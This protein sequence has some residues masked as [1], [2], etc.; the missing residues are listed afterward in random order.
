MTLFCYYELLLFSNRFLTCIKLHVQLSVYVTC[1][2]CMWETGWT[3]EQEQFIIVLKDPWPHSYSLVFESN[4]K[5]IRQE[6]LEAA[7]L[8]VLLLLQWRKCRW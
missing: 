5:S 8:Q 3:R 1:D 7:A 4:E 6:W 2:A